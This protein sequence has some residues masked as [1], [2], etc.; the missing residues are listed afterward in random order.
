[1]GQPPPPENPPCFFDA[2]LLG[3]EEFKKEML[4][5]WA[6]DQERPGNDQSWSAWLEA[7]IG[8]VMACNT[9][10]A[11]DK[12]CAQSKHVKTHVKKV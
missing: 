4:L 2:S 1:V 11:K 9:R 12:K 6:G 7:T 10:L 5:A 8:P 3:E